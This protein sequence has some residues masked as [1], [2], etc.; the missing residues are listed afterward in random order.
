ME[1]T[2]YRDTE[3]KR[4]PHFLPASTYNLARQ[5]LARCPDDYL[6]VPIRSMQYLAI[7]DKEEFIFIDGERKCWI[8][9]A[10]QN[11]HSQDRT[12]LSQPVAYEV[13]YYGE[14]QSDIMLRLQKEFPKSLQL[15][16]DKQIPKT[17]ARV[18]KF[19]VAQS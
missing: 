10:W 2:C 13:V 11:F 1:I 7:L 8:D 9:I 6:F 19:P 18:I 14:N 4:E 12:N 15:L 16:A 17:P 5:L 3:I